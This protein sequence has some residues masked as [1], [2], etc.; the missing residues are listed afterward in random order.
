MTLYNCWID[1]RGNKNF[2]KYEITVTNEQAKSKNKIYRFSGWNNDGK[3]L[4]GYAC[5]YF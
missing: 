5:Y 4:Y 1:I 3:N 2:K